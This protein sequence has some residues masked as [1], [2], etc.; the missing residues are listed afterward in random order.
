MQAYYRH[1]IPGKWHSAIPAHYITKCDKCSYNLPAIVC[2]T[3][4]NYYFLSLS[5]TNHHYTYDHKFKRSLLFTSRT[6]KK[7][8]PNEQKCYTR[9]KAIDRYRLQVVDTIDTV[10]ARHEITTLWNDSHYQ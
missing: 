3:I 5:L 4:I 1:R 9:R 10:L 7:N 8:R 6:I 2:P